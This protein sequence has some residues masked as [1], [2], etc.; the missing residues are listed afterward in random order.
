MGRKI[1]AVYFNDE[2]ENDLL[3]FANSLNN[4]SDWVKDKIKAEINKKP[5]LNPELKAIIEQYLA[6]KLK[7]V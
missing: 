2:T 5:E 1:K 3:S 7:S 6:E 4:F